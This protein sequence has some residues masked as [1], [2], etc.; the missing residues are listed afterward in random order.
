MTDRIVTLRDNSNNKVYPVG[1]APAGAVT[2]SMYT[3]ASITTP[4]LAD[5]SVTTSKLANNSVTADKLAPGAVGIDDI[6]DGTITSVKLADGSITSAKLA[7]EAVT[8]AKIADSAI[9]DGKIDWSTVAKLYATPLTATTT[10][11]VP[12]EDTYAVK[13][14]NVVI[15][16][17]NLTCNGTGYSFTDDGTIHEDLVPKTNVYTVLR[18]PWQQ[19]FVDFRVMQNGK[20]QLYSHNNVA[21]KGFHG[22][23]CYAVDDQ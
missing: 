23:I 7:S 2:T 13:I 10:T 12:S 19:W 1:F 14:G 8:T 16:V 17:I 3:D 15:L 6:S 5:G 22:V 11:I 21:N 9:T 20:W 18:E 4:K